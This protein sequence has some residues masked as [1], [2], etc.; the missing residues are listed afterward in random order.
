MDW[1]VGWLLLT[2]CLLQPL[3]LVLPV[4]PD[5]IDGDAGGDDAEADAALLGS[6]PEGHDDEEEAGQH[7]AHGQ[8][9]VH[10]LGGAKTT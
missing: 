5:V 4:N 10:L 2:D 1:L 8:Q 6:L 7:E 3:G 9:D